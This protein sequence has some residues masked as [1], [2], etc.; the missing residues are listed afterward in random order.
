[1][2]WLEMAVKG[3]GHGTGAHTELKV[4]GWRDI[5]SVGGAVNYNSASFL[6]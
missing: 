1:M 5:A 4:F 3:N 2:L 6:Y